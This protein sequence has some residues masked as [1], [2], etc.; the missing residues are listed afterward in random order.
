MWATMRW[1][2]RTERSSTCQVRRRISDVSAMPKRCGRRAARRVGH[3]VDG[4]AGRRAGCRPGEAP[5]RRG[6]APARARAGRARCGRGPPRRSPRRRRAPPPGTAASA[7]NAATLARARSA[8]SGAQLVADHVGPG[9]QQR[10]RERPRAHAGLE[11]PHAGADV[12][13]QQDGPEVLRVDDLG[14]AGHLEHHVGQGR[15]DDDEAAARCEP[16]H[17]DPLGPPMMSSWATMPA[18]VWNDGPACRRIRYRRSLASM[19]R[20]RSPAPK[21]PRRR[22]RLRLSPPVRLGRGGGLGG[23]DHQALAGPTRPFH[24]TSGPCWRA[25]RTSQTAMATASQ[26]GLAGPCPAA[27]LGS[28][29]SQQPVHGRL[30]PAGSRRWQSACGPDGGRAGRRST[31]DHH[32]QR[33]PRLRSCGRTASTFSSIS[34]DISRSLVSRSSRVILVVVGHHAASSSRCRRPHLASAGPFGDPPDRQPRLPPQRRP[35]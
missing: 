14:A 30:R 15:P 33:P 9:P 7:P 13:G 27:A 5:S 3:L 34:P 29:T 21:A 35:W 17:R 28:D 31:H 11:D 16:S 19:R 6:P 2:G 4:R 20:T 25:R 26:I 12:G 22:C 32:G 24:T 8:K 18:W 23:D 1:S 10:H